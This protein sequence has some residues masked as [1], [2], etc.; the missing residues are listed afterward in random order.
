M[1]YG[2]KLKSVFEIIALL[3]KAYFILSKQIVL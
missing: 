2:R 1:I 3:M